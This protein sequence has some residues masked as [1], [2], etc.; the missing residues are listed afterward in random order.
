MLKE[1]I[2]KISKKQKGI[3]LIA[4]VIT[5]ILLLILAG[6]SIS[7]LTGENGILTNSTKASIESKIAELKE[8]IKIDILCVQA[9]NKGSLDKS[10]FIEILK[11]YFDNVP[12]EVDL[13]ND[14]STLT[15]ISKEEYGKQAIKISEI[16]NGTFSDSIKEN[17]IEFTINDIQF[18]GVEGV[19]WEEWIKDNTDILTQNGLSDLAALPVWGNYIGKYIGGGACF[20][21]FYI[22]N[23]AYANMVR[24]YDKI[25][26]TDYLWE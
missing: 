21:A 10:Q 3:T 9:E 8:K 13:P 26:E 1:K 23:I 6:I 14:L 25:V 2:I 22:E 12:L 19:T 5:I 7:M 20:P 17:V 4:L 15:L 11:Q 16:W 24:T 18:E